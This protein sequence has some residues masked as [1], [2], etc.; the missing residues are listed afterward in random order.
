MVSK[1]IFSSFDSFSS[2]TLLSVLI[3]LSF[4]FFFLFFCS[5]LLKK[6][7]Y[8]ILTPSNLTVV[9]CEFNRENIFSKRYLCRCNR[10][11]VIPSV[12]IRICMILP[13][14]FASKYP[15]SSSSAGMYTFERQS[16][17]AWL[18]SDHLL[19]FLFKSLCNKIRIN[20]CIT[21]STFYFAYLP[22]V[23]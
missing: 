23:R 20:N 11:S 6:F 21:D 1:Q 8:I 13:A 22:N 16:N 19:T 5:F 7:F 17:F 3:I 10:S 14:T 15:S 18:L 4:V 12:S 9:I 2:S